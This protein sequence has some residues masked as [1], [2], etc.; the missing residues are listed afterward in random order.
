[1]K[2]TNLDIPSQNTWQL[3]KKIG[4]YIFPLNQNNEKNNI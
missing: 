4:R 3:W 1:M 2:I